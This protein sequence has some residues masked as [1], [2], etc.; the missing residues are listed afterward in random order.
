VD[1]TALYPKDRT[2][3]NHCCEHLKAYIEQPYWK[4]DMIVE[5]NVEKV[6][7][8]LGDTS[9]NEKSSY[10]GSKVHRIYCRTIELEKK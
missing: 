7:L 8:Q 1:Y 2:L 6:L 4:S 5:E 10:A 3:H 9:D